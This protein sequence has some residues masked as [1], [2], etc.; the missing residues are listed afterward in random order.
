MRSMLMYRRP[1]VY[2]V[3][4]SAIPIAASRR[5][6]SP[7]RA[8]TRASRHGFCFAPAQQKKHRF[9]AMLFVPR[10]GPTWARTRDP[11]IMSQVL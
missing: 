5:T 1:M 2:Q 10:C 9:A 3:S 4:A 6:G 7:R 8:G 11:L